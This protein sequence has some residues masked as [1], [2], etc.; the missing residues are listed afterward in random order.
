MAAIEAL[1]AAYGYAAVAL[2]MF[3][4]SIGIPLPSEASLLLTGIMIRKQTLALPLVMGASLSGA[5]VGSTASYWL[6]RRMGDRAFQR[7]VRLFRV[8][9]RRAEQ[10]QDWFRRHG[11][12]AVFVA[13]FIPFVRCLIGYPAGMMRIPFGNYMLYTLLGYAGWIGFSLSLG[14][15]GM[16]LFSALDLPWGQMAVLLAAVVAVW[17]TVK[18]LRK[19]R[20]P[21]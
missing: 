4:D 8:P 12:R 11:K 6:G 9:A 13:R 15:G 3:L 20:P 1:I 19:R 17:V 5:A 10:T 2:I 18:V 7:L 14:Y 21:I 16:A